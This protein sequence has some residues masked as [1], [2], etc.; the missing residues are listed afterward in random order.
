MTVAHSNRVSETLI[1][2]KRNRLQICILIWKKTPHVNEEQE[3]N[4]KTRKQIN[5]QTQHNLPTLSSDSNVGH[6]YAVSPL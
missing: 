5:K 4:T 1:G 6:Y 3:K 2:S